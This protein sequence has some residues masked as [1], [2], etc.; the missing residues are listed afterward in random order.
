MPPW[1]SLSH[2]DITGSISDIASY[3]ISA[4]VAPSLR[5]DIRELDHLG[6]LFG[7]SRDK[8]TEIV[9]RARDRR[10]SQV[11]KSCTHRRVAEAGVNLSIEL[12]YVFRW[13]LLWRA[14]SKPDAHLEPRQELPD[15]RDGR[16]RRRSRSAGYCE[17]D[18]K[19]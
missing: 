9:W 16:Q 6:P 1:P 14:E 7:F 10:C 17:R 12:V 11:C 3:G 2:I 19:S 4:S 5:L 8:P 15:S 18:R 13:S